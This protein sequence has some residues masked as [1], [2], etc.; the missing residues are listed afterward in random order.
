VS[1]ERQNKTHSEKCQRYQYW[2]DGVLLRAILA[3]AP[4]WDN[5]SNFNGPWQGVH[6]A[7]GQAMEITRARKTEPETSMIS[8]EGFGSRQ[9]GLT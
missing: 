5:S 7:H 1:A 4:N 9:V 2:L 3:E 6:V 8:M